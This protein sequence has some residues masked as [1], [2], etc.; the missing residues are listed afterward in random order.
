MGMCVKGKALGGTPD[1]TVTCDYVDVI[2]KVTPMSL[3]ALRRSFINIHLDP[4]AGREKCALC[5]PCLAMWT[6]YGTRRHTPHNVCVYKHD[7]LLN[8]NYIKLPPTLK[9]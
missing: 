3:P 8:Y 5:L 1:T 9:I 4:F 2:I 7:C 6:P